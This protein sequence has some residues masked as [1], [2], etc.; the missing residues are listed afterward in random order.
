MV[1]RIVIKTN[2]EEIRLKSFAAFFS[3]H[4]L[5]PEWVVF[6]QCISDEALLFL[7]PSWGPELLTAFAVL[8]YLDFLT[9]YRKKKKEDINIAKLSTIG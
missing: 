1:S 3:S 7:V 4:P 6:L 9:G 8:L 5:R 2:R